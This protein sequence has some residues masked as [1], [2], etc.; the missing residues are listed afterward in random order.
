MKKIHKNGIHY[1]GTHCVTKLSD[2]RL[3][4]FATSPYPEG[5]W[6]TSWIMQLRQRNGKCKAPRGFGLNGTLL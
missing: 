6:R 2:I 1:N 3:G 4:L 5:N